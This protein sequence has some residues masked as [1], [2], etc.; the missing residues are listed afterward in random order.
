MS[1]EIIDN[2]GYKVEKWRFESEQKE[3][4]NDKSRLEYYQKICPM[5]GIDS[6]SIYNASQEYNEKLSEAFENG[7]YV[8]YR[9]CFFGFDNL[10]T[11]EE[12]DR[13]FRVE[14]SFVFYS[15]HTHAI[16]KALIAFQYL[17]REPR[18]EYLEKLE[19]AYV[20]GLQE[21]ES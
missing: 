17:L 19:L 2:A 15:V 12:I 18:E 6:E 20:A 16:H 3:Y 11:R 4:L 10:K 5:Y 8:G 7:K 1:E 14:G 9:D 21:K 13:M